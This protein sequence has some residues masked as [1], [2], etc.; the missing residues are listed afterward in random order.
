MYHEPLPPQNTTRIEIVFRPQKA[1]LTVTLK[2]F[3]AFCGA[4][5]KKL[6]IGMVRNKPPEPQNH[7]EERIH[8]V[9]SIMQLSTLTKALR[10]VVKEKRK[11]VRE[12]IA[13]NTC[14]QFWEPE[15]LFETFPDAIEH[16]VNPQ[17]NQWV[18]NQ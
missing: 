15:K 12:Y 14:T 2:N 5:Y 9:F 17:S 1:K 18:V 6:A 3:E 16:I 8:S 13:A 11:E 10:S 4:R 7:K